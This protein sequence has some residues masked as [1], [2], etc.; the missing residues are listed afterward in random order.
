MFYKPVI[1]TNSNFADNNLEKQP[2][3][4]WVA[5]GAL[6]LF[7]I[8]G[9]ASGVGSI[10][11]LGYILLS[12]AVG[13]LLYLRYPITY[14]GFTWWLWFITP[15][16]SRVIDFRSGFDESRLILVTPFL[17]TLLTL[18]GCYKHLPRAYREGALPFILALLGVFYGFLI[19]LVNSSPVNAARALLDWL[20]P[21]SFATYLFINWRNYPQYRENFQRVF[22]WGVLITGIY[23]VI[24]YLIA[25]EWDRFWLISTELGSMGNPEPL[26]IR[27]W[28]TMASPGPFAVMMM[29]GLLILF[30]TRSPLGVPAA[31]AGYLS[32]LLSMVRVMWGCWII[33]VFSMFASMRPKMQMRLIISA[34]LIAIC[35]VPLS[36]MEP[37]GDTISDRLETFTNLENDNSA[38]VRQKIYEEGLNSAMS[39][40]LGNGVGNTFVFDETE[41]KW[42]TIVIDSG[43]LDTF[44]TLGWIGAIP[45]VAGLFL[46]LIKVIQI[47][48]IRLDPF[49]ASSRSI[50]IGCVFGIPIFSIMIGFSGILM[51]SFLAIALA[52]HKYYQQQKISYQQQLYNYENQHLFPGLDDLGAG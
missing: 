37:F 21:I 33:A 45:Y 27:V 6:I 38:Q 50:A 20:T 19:G 5:I 9:I 3:I 41:G 34:L 17:V 28:S 30:N 43:I 39:N 42:I 16:I 18:H 49:L 23:G 40:V 7:S 35:V 15:F 11:R 44:F 31:A 47:E 36:T 25:P 24:Q 26:G 14:I 52:G 29:S 2:V 22:L 12:F 13:I 10:F 32:F 4:A 46:L 8:A 48:E 1:P 51:W